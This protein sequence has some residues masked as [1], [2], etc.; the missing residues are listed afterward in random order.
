MDT[1]LWPL[2]FSTAPSFVRVAEVA[3]GRVGVRLGKWL[4]PLQVGSKW[5]VPFSR[6]LLFVGFRVPAK[7]MRLHRL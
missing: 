4:G 6:F 5:V 7:L 1:P 2:F 3:V